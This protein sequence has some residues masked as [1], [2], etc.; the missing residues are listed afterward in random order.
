MEVSL[1][2]FNIRLKADYSHVQIAFFQP[3]FTGDALY[4]YYRTAMLL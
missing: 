2:A 3:K 4:V 1:N